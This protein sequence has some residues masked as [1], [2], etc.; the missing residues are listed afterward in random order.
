MKKEKERFIMVDSKGGYL[1]NYSSL[2]D[3]IYY[4]KFEKDARIFTLDKYNLPKLF[5]RLTFSESAS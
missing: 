2:E 3:A 4:S 1:C 5:N